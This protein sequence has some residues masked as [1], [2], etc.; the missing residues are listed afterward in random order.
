MRTTISFN[1]YPRGWGA[2]ACCDQTTG[3]SASLLSPL[4]Y[5]EGVDRGAG[6]EPASADSKSAVLPLDDPRL[7]FHGPRGLSYNTRAGSVLTLQL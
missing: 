3:I 6:L 7:T 4:S 5:R 2:R 1:N